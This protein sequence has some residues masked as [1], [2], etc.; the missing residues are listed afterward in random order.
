MLPSLCSIY[1]H[2]Q[3]TAIVYNTDVLYNINSSTII[4]LQHQHYMYYKQRE[5]FHNMKP[6]DRCTMKTIIV[7]GLKTDDNSACSD[8][9]MSINKVTLC[10]Y[11]CILHI[12]ILAHYNTRQYTQSY[13]HMP[14]HISVMCK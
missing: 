4:L 3:H 6:Y 7:A 1:S 11:E 14:N 9:Q 13:T 2:I 10:L 12:Y 8:K 5:L